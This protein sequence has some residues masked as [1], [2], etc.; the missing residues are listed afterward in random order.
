MR[1]PKGLGS[2][3][4]TLAA[5]IGQ[6][7]HEKQHVERVLQSVYSASA[8][9]QSWLAASWRRSFEAHG[10]DPCGRRVGERL[11][12]GPLRQRQ[13]ALAGVMALSRTRLESLFKLVGRS[14]CAILLTDAEGMVV[15][16]LCA[17][18]DAR[19]FAQWGLAPGWD[20]SEASEGTN[21]I[22][23]CLVERRQVTIAREEHF[24]VCNGGLSCMDAPIFGPE[25]EL[26]AALDVSTAR[27]DQT[28]ATI[29][30]IGALVAETSRHIESD[31]FQAAYPNARIIIVGPRDGTGES[32]L[33]VDGDDLVV[34]AT[35]RARKL[36]GFDA[37]GGLTP[38]PAGDL[39]AQNPGSS[40]FEKGAR[41]AIV[42]ALAR[43][44][45]NVSQAAR[46][47]GVGRATLYRR[48][49]KL[50]VDGFANAAVSK[51]RQ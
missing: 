43:A 42:R 7:M 31:L 27:S 10:L 34:G 6:A 13:D 17:D 16:Q 38:R 9:A 28:L 29:S 24:L 20:W 32:L 35:R 44:D 2:R 37:S 19:S 14:G 41:A 11:E 3:C 30:M 1:S 21:G 49:K 36:L 15:D 23:T 12:D 47:L 8:A 5:G 39:F 18:G 22:G 33:A 25:G 46:A 48:M 51:A 50:G 26:V 45:G 40:G 4:W